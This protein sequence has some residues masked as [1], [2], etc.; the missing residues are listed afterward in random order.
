MRIENEG[1]DKVNSQTWKKINN[2]DVV[3]PYMTEEDVRALTIVSS[4]GIF[5]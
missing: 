2:A 4:Q 5:R 1:L 3:F